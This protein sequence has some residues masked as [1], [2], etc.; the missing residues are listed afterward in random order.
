[1]AFNN[2][3]SPKKLLFMGMVVLTV[4]AGVV[5]FAFTSAT[6]L[7][8]TT[9]ETEINSSIGI[10]NSVN[11]LTDRQDETPPEKLEITD[12]ISKA[13]LR[14]DGMSCSGCIYTIKSSLSDFTGVQYVL[15]NLS[16]RQVEVYYQS[17]QLKDVKR[18][19]DAITASGYPAKVTEVLSAGQIRKER[20]LAAVR[21]LNYIASVGEWDISRNDFNT[22]QEHAKNR[23]VL[24]YGDDILTSSQGKT[25]LD[26]L[27]SQIASRLIDEGIQMQ[28]IKKAGYTV[29]KA[30]VDAAF[31]N[32]LKQKAVDVEKFKTDL[33]N[34]GY[35]FDYFMKKFENRVLINRYLEDNIFE[36]ATNSFEKQRRYASWFNNAKLLSKVVYYDKE[37]ER[38][39]QAS[40][41]GGCSGG[42]SCRAKKQ[43]SP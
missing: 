36:N 26:N 16:N 11:T 12:N 20:D 8:G 10:N 34:A 27:K 19:A 21:S 39:V 15:V 40:S 30:S 6:G 22:E 41:A 13:V 33:E 18:I 3:S 25:L 23:Y 24:V 31:Q 28:E 4:I 17:T 1:M 5:F 9:T 37:I 42:S 38:L 32:Y 35:S 29:G 43:T 2:F 14:V 7:K